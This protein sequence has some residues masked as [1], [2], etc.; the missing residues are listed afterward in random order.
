MVHQQ[1]VVFFKT[2][3]FEKIP[4]KQKISKSR[5]ERLQADE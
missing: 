1:S 2:D 3:V 4:D 5:K